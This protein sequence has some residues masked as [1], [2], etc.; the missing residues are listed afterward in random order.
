MNWELVWTRPAI[1]DMKKIGHQEAG[2]IREKVKRV[3]ETGYGDV[4][5]LTDVHPPVWRQRVGDWRVF[6]S[7][8]LTRKRLQVMRV[9][10][11]DQ[12]Y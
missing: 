12:A 5:K 9:R 11:R 6:I 1:R 3:A 4:R 10:R 7:P 2:R 8:D